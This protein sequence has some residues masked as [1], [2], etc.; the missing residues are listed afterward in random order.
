MQ[1]NYNKNLI[2]SA[3]YLSVI[4]AL[5]ILSAKLYGWFA[6]S[7]QSMLASLVDSMLDI[8][9]SFINL[10]A[11]Y[12]G[13]QPPDH[14]HRFG[15]EKFQDL[16]IFSQA[17]FFLISG[18]FTISSGIKAIFIKTELHQPQIV[19]YQ[20]Y[21]VKKTNSK[22]IEADKLHYVSDFLTNIAVIIAI[23][24]SAKWWI[25]D[26]LSGIAIS[27]Y[28]VYTALSLFRVAIRNLADEEFPEKDKKRI[29]SI[30]SEYPEVKGVHDLKT[31]YAS[32]K[33]FIQFHIE[34][35]GQ[36]LL[37][38]AHTISE[39]I[40]DRILLEFPEGEVTIHQDPEG[41]DEKVDYR[42]QI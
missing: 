4:I 21:V 28:I 11:L 38:D 6:T 3:S 17:I 14:N 34:M 30:I 42:E 31:R 16:A 10:I 12:F 13:L 5:I 33:A 23:N 18:L 40:C 24:L 15:H 25:I 27:I 2:K 1:S 19:L 26:A 9:A 35:D 41:V 29:L 8:S 39:A 37:V 22:V 7:S 20:T 32:N 36:M